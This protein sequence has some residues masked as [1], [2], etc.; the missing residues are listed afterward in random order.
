MANSFKNLQNRLQQLKKEIEPDEPKR[1]LEA[2]SYLLILTKLVNESYL[3]E[4]TS[5]YMFIKT[6]T[7]SIYGRL[8]S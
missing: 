2:S 8:S 3:Q 6:L 1:R 4:S 7:D 5:D